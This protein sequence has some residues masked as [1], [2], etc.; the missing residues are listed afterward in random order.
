MHLEFRVLGIAIHK[1]SA[2]GGSCGDIFY[3]RDDVRNEVHSTHENSN[4]ER[5]ENRDS[6]SVLVEAHFVRSEG[7]TP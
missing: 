6:R 2:K 3:S 4:G 7:R 1:A 5:I